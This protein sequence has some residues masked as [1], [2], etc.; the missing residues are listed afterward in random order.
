MTSYNDLPIYLFKKGTNYEAFKFFRPT[1]VM[2]DGKKQWRFRCW[3]P[4][5]KSVSIIGDFNDWNRSSHVMKKIDDEIF[6]GYV[7]GLKK[8][9]NYKFSILTQDNKY[10]DKADPYATHA[11]TSPGTASKLYDVEG[12]KWHDQVFMD[13][14]K[15][16]NFVEKPLNIYE[17]HLGSWKIHDDGNFYSYRQLA[18]ELVDY[19]V[20]MGY[21]HIEI[22]PVTEFPYDG[23]W[24]YQVSG[25]YAPTS[26][27]GEP[28]DFMYFVDKCHEKGIGVIMDFVLS[29]FPKDAFGLAEFDGQCLYEYKDPRKGEHKEWGTKVFD[30]GYGSVKSFLIS[31]VMFF[32]EYYHIDGIR[33][34]AVASMLY[35]DYGRKDGEWIPNK[36]G[37]NYNL[38]AI[39]FLK[40][41]N[42][43]VH[44]KFPEVIMIAEESTAFPMVTMPPDIGGLG[45]N[46]KWNMGWMND[47]LD[48]CKIDPFFRKGAHNK[49][50]FSLMYAF[51]ENYIL[52][53]SHDEVVH[54]KCSMIGKMQGSYEDK[55]QALKS[56]YVYQFT[57]P[58]KKLNFMGNE[59]GQFIEWNYKQGLDWLLLDYESHRALKEFCKDLNHLYKSTPAL[60]EVDNKYDGFE[61]LVVD[62]NVNNV[63]AYQRA[64]KKSNKVIAVIN[65]SSQTLV[66]YDIGVDEAGEYEVIL[67]TNDLKYD[68]YTSVSK[69]LVA[70]EKETKG[71]K[72]TLTLTVED[73]SSL[74]I[75]K[76]K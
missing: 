6:E 37:G 23:S 49:L 25:L 57:H 68:G 69:V 13:A 27:F 40:D 17:V 15:G 54:G 14:K 26:R 67:N 38:E 60:Y 29:H 52:P 2:H 9:D 24:G 41:L 58:G 61:W 32:L 53:F 48:Y 42:T 55:F 30:F 16:Q 45:F 31:A 62:D 44:Q 46:Y 47:V 75:R 4:H 19:V 11:E 18:D 10:L 35:L 8:F 66:G 51:S 72:Y 28:K 74:L 36:D 34:D 50:T 70:H 76:I 56:L 71:K 65:F 64:D 73:N 43:A 33:M 5:A 21:T 20:D 63:L 12:Y 1:Y 7:Q 3:A 22:L 59:F 39:E